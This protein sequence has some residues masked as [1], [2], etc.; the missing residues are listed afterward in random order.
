[1]PVSRFK[2]IFIPFW[3]SDALA[4]W[5]DRVMFHNRVAIQ[6]CLFGSWLLQLSG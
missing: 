1:M 6:G 5:V 4:A 2:K 3:E